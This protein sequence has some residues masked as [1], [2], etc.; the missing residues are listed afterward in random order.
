MGRLL[1]FKK[2]N[3]PNEKKKKTKKKT[4]VKEHRKFIKSNHG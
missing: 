2:K 1:M 3:V 4:S